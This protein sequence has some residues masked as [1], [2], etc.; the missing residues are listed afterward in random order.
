M[1]VYKLTLLSSPQLQNYPTNKSLKTEIEMAFVVGNNLEINYF[2]V[3]YA[4]A[5][6]FIAY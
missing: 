6:M 2:S 1:L 4:Y 3:K 5:I